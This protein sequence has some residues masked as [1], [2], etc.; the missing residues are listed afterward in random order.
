MPNKT[1]NWQAAAALCLGFGLSTSAALA[2]SSP[3]AWLDLM[4]E[5]VQTT[6]YEG[7]VVRVRGGEAEALK[8]VHAVTDG[9]IREKVIA[10]EGDGLE[11]IRNGNEVH[12]ILPERKSVIVEEW[13]NQSTLFSTLPSSDIRFG[14]EYDVSIVRKE[15]VAGR[16]A[17]LLA[18]RP[19][20]EFRYGHRLWLDAE[21][22]FPLQTQLIDDG[23]EAIAQV[24]F[25]DI[26]LDTEIQTSALAPSYSID[27]FTWIQ[28]PAKS[29]TRQPLESE[30]R[31]DNLPSGFKPVSAHAEEMPG[32][33]GLVTHVLFSDGIASV[34]VFVA[35]LEGASVQGKSN[36]G[37]SHSYSVSNGDHVIT[38]VG[39]VPAV[40]V[41]QIARSMRRD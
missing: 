6:N 15:R 34:S 4:A 12:C 28:E 10:Q 25:A 18:I 41:E 19:H 23:G 21:T 9:V 20:D 14:S 30:W 37:S 5:A 7:T 35:F 8:V 1:Q 29:R 22:G 16:K 24:K 38:A 33:D 32:N 40:T 26:R 27:T 3:Q 2:Q 36:H 31:S 13:D 11:I 17:V 39:E